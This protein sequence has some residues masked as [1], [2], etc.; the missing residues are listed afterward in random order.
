MV[1]KVIS[2]TFPIELLSCS[3]FIVQVIGLIILNHRMIL[4]F[5][6][7]AEEKCV[8]L[9][10]ILRGELMHDNFRINGYVN[11]KRKQ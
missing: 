4:F 9:R 6:A 1:N 8:I 5:A 3:I 2:S 10:A 7:P 11:S